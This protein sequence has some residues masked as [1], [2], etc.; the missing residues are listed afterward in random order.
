M[1]LKLFKDK[2]N[3]GFLRVADNYMGYDGAKEA[4]FVT[5][6]EYKYVQKNDKFVFY[7]RYVTLSNT[8]FEAYILMIFC[9]IILLI[10]IMIFPVTFI[11]ARKK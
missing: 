3:G 5:Y 10:S 4:A 9:L 11:K 1:S 2:N 6:R 7:N 8:S